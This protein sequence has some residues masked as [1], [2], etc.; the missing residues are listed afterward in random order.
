ML[1]PARQASASNL[2]YDHDSP[3]FDYIFGCILQVKA[4]IRPHSYASVRYTQY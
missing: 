1:K 3:S 4:F 2:D